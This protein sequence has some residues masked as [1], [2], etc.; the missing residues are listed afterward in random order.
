MAATISNTLFIALQLI[1]GYNLVFPIILYVLYKTRKKKAITISKK[2]KEHDYA[3]ILT[4]YEQTDTIP[5]AIDSIL[6][7]NYSNYIVYI[8]AD[9]CDTSNLNFSDSRVVVLR[10]P[11]EL[12]SNT[13]SHFF[14]IR[15]FIRPHEYLTII[16]ADNLVD[17]EYLNELNK[18]FDTGVEAVQG[19]R[20]AKNLN[21]T[22]AC[23][24][25]A[26]DIYYHFY[27]GQVLYNIGS[28]ATLAGSGMA[29]KTSLYKECLGH[30]NVTGAGFDKVL[31]K[32]I[33]S[34]GH[35]IAFTELA[36]VYDE[37]T[38]NSDQLVKQRARWMSTWFRYSKFGFSL[39]ASG[40]RSF[41]LNK[42]LFGLVL[43]R[44]PLF[45][46][47]L[48]SFALL[49]GNLWISATGTILWL[50][51]MCC[52]LQGFVVA[53]R[54]SNPDKRIIKSLVN[55]PKFIFYQLR[56][57]LLLKNANKISVATQHY[58]NTTISEMEG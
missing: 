8:V 1:I 39:V 50:I 24:D 32:E 26:R 3:I 41:D 37:K 35:R 43:L 34:R 31:Q 51:G 16:D 52:F 27:D 54:H 17:P 48:L 10:P 19:V 44:P 20:K 21:T 5:A 25:A 9:K 57:L 53:M 55:A 38:S 46:F 42:F 56:S 15:N 22:Y 11:E 6:K 4:A 29:F 45:I 12:A 30:L 28:S 2:G 7:L 58:N 23:L 33:V 18:C 47:L 13:R 14:A 40:V 49:L 36:L